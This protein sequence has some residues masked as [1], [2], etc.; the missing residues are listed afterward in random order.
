MHINVDKA[1]NGKEAV[2]LFRENLNRQCCRSKYKIV[3]MDLNMP[4]MDGY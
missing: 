3:L 2:E 1:L 4:I